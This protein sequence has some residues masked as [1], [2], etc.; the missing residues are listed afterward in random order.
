MQ[1]CSI[2]AHELAHSWYGNL[3]SLNWWSE[4]WLN[5]GFAEFMMYKATAAVEPT[6]S[7][8]DHF[9][10]KELNRVFD[11]DTSLSTHPI[12]TP[13]R[14]END[15]QSIFDP[16]TYAKGA[17]II[18]M[19]ENTIGEDNFRKAVSNYMKKYSYSNTVS[20]QLWAEF[21][22]VVVASKLDVGAMMDTWISREGIPVVTVLTNNDGTFSFRQE[23]FL[24]DF[25]RSNSSYTWYI[26][27]TYRVFDPKNADLDNP[28]GRIAFDRLTAN[29]TIAEYSA[30]NVIKFNVDQTGV[31]IL[32]YPTKNWNQFIDLL[33]DNSSL[34]RQKLSV[35]DRNNLLSDAFYLSR[36]GRLSYDI[37]LKLASAIL[38][39]EDSFIVWVT[40][41][42]ML[43][44]LR[45]F[46]ITEDQ[47]IAFN[48]WLLN[49]GVSRLYD[50]LGW[51]P[52]V[53]ENLNQRQLRALVLDLACYADHGH[54]LQ[55]A[56]QKFAEFQT[57]V[58]GRVKRSAAYTP[59]P[60][61][62]NVFLF[63]TMRTVKSESDS[64]YSFLTA[65]YEN[66]QSTNEKMRYLR[67]L[68]AVSEPNLLAKLVN[69]SLDTE[70]L[71]PQ[72]YFTFLAYIASNPVGL[73][74]AWKSYRDNFE[75][76]QTR[77]GLDDSN[78]G[79][80]VYRFASYF[81]SS[82]RQTE[83]QQFFSK[84]PKGK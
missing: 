1:V 42:D 83:V 39:N 20:T 26:P 49:N 38:N 33:S 30:D 10:I 21:S 28:I 7:Y 72:D 71:R 78:L 29:A 27:L 62:L 2:I 50:Q 18:R 52:A 53:D 5:E 47:G 45:T 57:Q 48:Q 65:Q 79:R 73:D 81:T 59:D 54:C 14:D 15:M 12:L 56:N 75:T 32:N 77:F 4:L 6:W 69:Q 13:V 67:A 8:N 34:A 9:I 61:L 23:R 74:I 55:T 3:V 24:K 43:R 31:Y 64:K 25:D 37:T 68:S 19:L 51:E 84:Y 60:D 40:A 82:A 66:A 80:A 70:F 16:V 11:I 63:H 44:F 76:I 36:S 58:N 41:S 46:A 22:D 35:L 17:S